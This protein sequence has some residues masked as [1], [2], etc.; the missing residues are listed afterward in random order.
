M[1]ALAFDLVAYRQ[2]RKRKELR[3]ELHRKLDQLLDDLEEEMK[4]EEGISGLSELIIQKREELTSSIA[5]EMIKERYEEYLHQRVAI[6]RNCGDQVYTMG[7]RIRVIQTMVGQIRLERP[8]FYCRR[9]KKGFYPLDEALGLSEGKAQYDLQR[10]MGKLAKELPYSVA[11]ELFEDLTGVRISDRK[12]H[13]VTNE[14][15]E[16]LS[17]LDVAPSRGEI[18][19]KVEEASKGKGWRPILVLGIDGVMVPTRPEDAKKKRR[20]RKKVRAKRGKWKGEWREAK[21]FR[22][23]LVYGDRI[24]P[25]MCWYQIQSNDDLSESLR[26]V[27]EAGLIPEDKIRLCVIGDGIGWIWDCVE[28][29]FPKAKQILDYY[30]LSRYLHEVAQA[31]YK[32]D[33]ERGQ[34]WIEATLARLFC[35]EVEGVI[36]GLAR[37]KKEDERAKEAIE[38][39]LR[40]LKRHK[41]RVDYGSAKKGGYPIGSGGVESANR[42]LAQ[43]RLKRSGAWWYRENAN[44]MLALR[45]AGYNGTFDRVFKRYVGACRC[46]SREDT[47]KM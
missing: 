4:D 30:H 36:W 47:T 21:G 13:E 31:R 34:H 38:K 18:L 15:G 37:M 1:E 5:C 39:C 46:S 42:F 2:D 8:Y 19:E 22:F 11:E 24:E 35:G 33:P 9:C 3:E 41:E 26:Q 45:S 28:E 6:C 32:D 40:Y 29:I 44:R 27:K 43:A 17:V 14:I 12:M 10:R 7:K 23:Y 16:G 25:V 20:G